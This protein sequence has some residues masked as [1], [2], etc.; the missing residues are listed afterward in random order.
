MVAPVI[1]E[2]LFWAGIAGTV[3]GAYWLYVHDNWAWIMALVFGCLLTRVIFEF[4]LLAFRSYDCLLDIRD[5]LR[6]DP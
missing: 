4:F 5:T 6:R 1:L 3:Y 2:L